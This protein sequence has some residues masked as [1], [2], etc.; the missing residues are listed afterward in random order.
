LFSL[1][2]AENIYGK[3][4]TKGEGGGAKKTKK[5]RVIYVAEKNS[6]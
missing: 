3:R 2:S 6:D 1:F 5:L 4:L